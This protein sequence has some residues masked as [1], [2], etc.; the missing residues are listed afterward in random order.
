MASACR[1]RR[2][3]GKGRKEAWQFSALSLVGRAAST[4]TAGSWNQQQTMAELLLHE[5][6]GM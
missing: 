6:K 5:F 4:N 1:L 3:S 2:G